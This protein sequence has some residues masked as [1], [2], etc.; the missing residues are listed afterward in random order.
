M[1][2][3]QKDLC[4]KELSYT[5]VVIKKIE[6]SVLLNRLAFSCLLT[7]AAFVWTTRKSGI[8]CQK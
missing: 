1:Y 5:Y 3:R 4:Q 7:K 6:K 2:T 8:C